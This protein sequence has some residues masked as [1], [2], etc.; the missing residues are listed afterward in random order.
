MKDALNMIEHFK[1]LFA[2]AEDLGTV[3]STSLYS[4]YATVSGKT[5]N[6][7]QFILTLDIR[8]ANKNDS[9]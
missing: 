8:E 2:L 4:G 7:E 3:N 9:V 5:E 1:K 6:G